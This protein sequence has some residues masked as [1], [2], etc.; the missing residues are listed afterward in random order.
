MGVKI[1]VLDPTPNCPASVVAEQVVGSFRD[2]EA[3]KAF[4]QGVDV[5][6]VEIE[7]ID[8]DAM[9]VCAAQ[10]GHTTATAAAAAA[11]AAAAAAAGAAAA[12]AAAA[13]RA[14][15]SAVAAS[16]LH[17]ASGHSFLNTMNTIDA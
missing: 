16:S 2:A 9:Q 7:H 10:L 4:A 8:A 15:L 3:V 6:T 1:K 14:P 12:A 13:A 17:L 11:G 5:L